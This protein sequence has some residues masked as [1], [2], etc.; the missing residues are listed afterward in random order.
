MNA[1]RACDCPGCGNKMRLSRCIPRFGILPE[2]QIFSC[3][4]CGIVVSETGYDRG[5]AGAAALLLRS[6]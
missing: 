5:A 6:A 1:E 4:A 3:R 2:L